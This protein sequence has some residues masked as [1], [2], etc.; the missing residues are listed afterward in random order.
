MTDGNKITCRNTLLPADNNRIAYLPTGICHIYQDVC[1][2]QLTSLE[3]PKFFLY[4]CR[5]KFC[6]TKKTHFDTHTLTDFTLQNHSGG[7]K[8][9]LEITDCKR[10]V[11]GRVEQ[12]GS[13]RTLPSLWQGSPAL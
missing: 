9:P 12:S 1:C 8:G 6:H 11:Q 2:E 13:L 3:E 7:Q 10:P 5:E 4:S